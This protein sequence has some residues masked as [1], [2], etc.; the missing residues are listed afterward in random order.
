MWKR[1]TVPASQLDDQLLH[2]E[3]LEQRTM[4]STVQ[5]FAAGSD[6]TEQMQLRIDGVAVQTWQL[7]AGA[8]EGNFRAYVFESNTPLNANQV[9]VEFLNDNYD[10]Q[11]GIDANLRLDAISIDGVRFETE[12]PAVFSTGTYRSA[13]GIV[14][15]FRQS[16]YLHTNGYFQFFDDS[17][18]NEP[19]PLTPGSVIINEIHYNPGP[20][21]VVDGDAEFLELL[22]LTDQD[23]NLSGAS[24]V[25]FT[26]IF[27]EGTI[28]GAGEYAIVGPS[29]ALA[30]STW[31]VTPI[32]EFAAGGLS[33]SGELIRFL[34]ADGVTVIDEV[35]YLDRGPWPTVPDGNGPSLELRDP[36]LDNSLAASWGASIG[37]PTPGAPNSI[38]GQEDVSITDIVVAPEVVLPGQ[39]FNISATI[40]GATTA[41]VVYKLG[42]DGPEQSVQMTAVGNTWTATLPGQNAGELIRYRIV[43]DVAVAPFNDTI[44]FFGLVVAPTDIVNNTLPVFQFWVNE[45]QFQELTTTELALTNTTIPAVIAYGNQVFDNA[46]VRVRGGDFSR[47]THIK[48]SL[49]FELPRG[50]GLNIGGEGGYLIDEFGVNADFSDW[51]VVIPDI[52]WDV[53]NA[54]TDSF[55][56]SFFMYV[57]RNSGYHGIFRFQELY[58]GAWRTANGFANGDE[59]YD[60]E[61]GG[62]GK[63]PAFDKKSPDDADFATLLDLNEAL[64]SQPSATKTAFLYR[65]IDVPN[66]INHMAISTLM[67]HDDQSGQNFSVWRKGDSGTWSIV[68][69]DL[70]R[71]WVFPPDGRGADFTTPEPIRAELLD[72]IWEVPEFRD[73]YWRRIQTLVD[74][75]LA[76]DLLIDRHEELLQ[77]IGGSNFELDFEKWGRNNPFTNRFW[78]QEFNAGI[79]QR[80]QAFA[81]ESRMPGTASGSFNIVINELHYNPVSGG[82]EFIELFNNSD[83]S[84][85][86]SG[87]RIDGIGLTIPF[88]TVILPNQTVVFTDNWSQFKDQYGGNIFVGGQYSGQLSNGGETIT[89]LDLDGNVI[90]LVSYQDRGAWPTA[91]DGNGVSLALIDPNR[92]NSLAANWVASIQANGSPG[93]QNDTVF[94]PNTIRIFAAGDTGNEAVTLEIAGEVVAT[95]LLSDFGGQAG[96]LVARDFVTLT[97]VSPVPVDISEVRINF[98]NDLNDIANGIDHN[99]AIDRIE[100]DFDIFETEAATVFST[101]TYLSVDG[102]VPGVR[103]SEVLHA[104]GFFQ[105]GIGGIGRPPVANADVAKTIENDAVTIDV[106]ANDSDSDLADAIAIDSF[107]QA[108]NGTVSLSGDLLVYTPNEGFFGQDSFTYTIADRIGNTSSATVGIT[109]LDSETA[110]NT[111]KVFAA[112]STGNEIITLEIGGQV[113]GTYLMSD[114]GG[115]AGDLGRR[116][117]VE[118]SYFAEGPINFSDVRINFVNDV[119]DVANGIDYNVAIDRIEIGLIGFETESSSVLSTGTWVSGLGLVP[120]FWQNEIL[121]ANGY[122]QYGVVAAL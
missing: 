94:T 32:A 79:E 93:L 121:H 66:V 88:G 78:Q 40:T 95:Y 16:E 3:P 116:S 67:R 30:E 68:E 80:R 42:F 117:F 62:F 9:R 73:M 23:I 63:V 31:G 2:C 18:V 111:I 60:A 102:L 61:D 54:E 114:F 85:D 41:T 33:G 44:N 70:D 26:L 115:Q 47:A 101:G 106:L 45:E 13:D 48:K 65:N 1:R 7:E 37:G 59:F 113:V 10:P 89:L 4:L 92:D 99:V 57:Q 81:N 103:R 15:G 109:V 100:I 36:G 49:K 12:D 96:D 105:Y 11:N 8:E 38:F 21:G 119:F 71:T 55:T 107:T 75:Y 110:F 122:F 98:I 86:L 82:A 46:T 83:E 14:P 97:Y 35:S 25:G 29:I 39:A 27:A 87:W 6:G 118:I 17:A 5:L 34:A 90:D 112:G 77:Q 53:F 91:P 104:N 120:G 24:F 50:Y 52:S 64:I 84:V 20:D 76:D 69:W 108:S 51:S 43:S 58:D 19:A 56:S 74:K 28:L 72:A 22:N